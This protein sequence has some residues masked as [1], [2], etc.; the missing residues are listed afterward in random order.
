MNTKSYFRHILL[1]GCVLHLCLFACKER[2]DIN[3]EASSP[4][5]VVYGFI[6]TD[7][8]QHAI[9]ITRSTGYFV[10]TRPEAISKAT[11]S[12]SYDNEVIKLNESSRIPGSYLTPL[13]FYGIPGKTYT[14]H[15]SLDFNED[16][17]MEEYEATSYLPFPAILDSVA[18]TP[19][20]LTNFLQVLTWGKLP[21]ENNCNFNF[22]L[23]RNSNA[24]NDYLKGFRIFQINKKFAALRVF[25]LNPERESENLLPGDTLTVQVESFTSEYATFIQNAQQELLGTVPLFSGPPANVETNIR[26]LSSGPKPEISGFFT[27]YSKHRA[28]TVYDE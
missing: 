20:L 11:V 7:T 25:L 2:I 13:K 15:I 8:T 14:L 12:I 3:T 17:E 27:T 9:R 19:F 18:V 4:R 22:H 16:G 26:C 1:A 10:T 28:F 21:E 6:T 24:I 5:L 23:F